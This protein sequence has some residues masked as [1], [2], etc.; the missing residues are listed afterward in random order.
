MVVHILLSSC[1]TEVLRIVEIESDPGGLSPDEQKGVQ[2]TLV[3]SRGILLHDN[4]SPFQS[5]VQYSL[6]Q[7][8]P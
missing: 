7:I 6:K 3:L 8:T 4:H 2:I 1:S 5:I